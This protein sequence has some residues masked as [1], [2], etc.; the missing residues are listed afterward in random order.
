MMAF[1]MATRQ[2]RSVNGHSPQS[3]LS[4]LAHGSS[5]SNLLTRIF[6]PLRRHRERTPQRFVAAANLL[7]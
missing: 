4:L 2:S 3:L 6:A 1:I 7:R 5:A